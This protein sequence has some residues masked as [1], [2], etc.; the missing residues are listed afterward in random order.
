MGG[1]GGSWRWLGKMAA[2][3]LLCLP[4]MCFANQT[5]ESAKRIADEA[6]VPNPESAMPASLRAEPVAALKVADE[7]RVESAPAKLSKVENNAIAAAL[8]DGVSTQLVL[9]AGGMEANALAASFP[10][11]LVGL[12]GAKVM[13]ALYANKLPEHDK[14]LV[15]KTTS[16][17]WGGAAVNNL[18]VL[19][20]A[21]PPVPI[22]AGILMGVVV[23]RHTGRAYDERDRLAAMQKAKVAT[24]PVQA[25]LEPAAAAAP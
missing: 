6:I 11:G 25:S 23:W 8:A 18:L 20:A 13:L 17:T 4:V 2:V 21:P 22:V 15:I 14:R 3:P 7:T 9:S 16:A 19:M 12:T 10:M 1:S 24:E 5:E